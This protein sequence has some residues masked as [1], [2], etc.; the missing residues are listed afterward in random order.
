MSTALRL[1]KLRAA[2]SCDNILLMLDIVIKHFGKAQKLGLAIR[3]SDHYHARCLLKIRIFEKRIEHL[4]RIGILL[5]FDNCTDSRAV[6]LVPDI[7][8]SGEL[9]LFSL[10]KSEYFFECRG[11]VDLIW[12]F[13][14]DDIC[15][16]VLQRLKMSLSPIY[17]L[18]P[19]RFIRC[20]DLRRVDNISARRKIRAWH[21]L[22]QLV[23]RYL[24]VLYSRNYS[25]N[26]F[27]R[28]MRKYAGSQ[29]YCN[30]V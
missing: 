9:S 25:I 14:D 30:T 13:G 18:A 10:H 5:D 3:N 20:F 12:E 7:R 24:R 29:T 4:L 28:I 6:G 27:M 19:A 17:Q 26:G 1:F 15:F 21:Y 23:H 2:S 16:A 8:N 11:L 22:H